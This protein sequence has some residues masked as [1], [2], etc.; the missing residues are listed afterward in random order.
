MTGDAPEVRAALQQLSVAIAVVMEDHAP[1]AAR[2]L[3]VRF[4]ELARRFLVLR[5]AGADIT[6]I[7]DGALALTRQFPTGEEQ[8]EEPL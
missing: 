2:A 7:A 6:A 3:P 1:T 5:R 4:V 8:Q